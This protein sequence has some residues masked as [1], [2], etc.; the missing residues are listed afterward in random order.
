M[1]KEMNKISKEIG[2]KK[3]ANKEDPC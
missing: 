1:Q 3:K 2:L